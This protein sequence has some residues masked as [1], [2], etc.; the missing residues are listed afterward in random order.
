MVCTSENTSAMSDSAPMELD[1]HQDSIETMYST[2]DAVLIK[3]RR[4]LLDVDYTV[5]N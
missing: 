3:V 1:I 4:N 2:N 5:K